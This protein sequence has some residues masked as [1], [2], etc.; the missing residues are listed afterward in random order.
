M[1]P[2]PKKPE[3]TRDQ[4]QPPQQTAAEAAQRVTRNDEMDSTFPW[5]KKI[6]GKDLGLKVAAEPSD[7]D[8]IHLE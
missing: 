8:D 4:S 6:T 7:M 2:S 1:D 5:V 3:I